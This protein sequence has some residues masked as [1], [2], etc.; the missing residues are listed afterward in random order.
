MA[1]IYFSDVFEVS[2][3]LLEEHGAFNISLITDLPL[4]IDPFLLF[5]SEDRKYKEL[6][7]SII[8]YMRF[9]KDES[10]DRSLPEPLVRQ[11]FTF[12]EIRQNW[13]GFSKVGNRGR[14]LGKD[15]A[16]VLNR[17]LNS[18]FSDFGQETVTLSSHIEKFC[19]IRDGVGRDMISDFTA[20]L[21]KGYLCEFTQEFARSH[22]PTSKRAVYNVDH[23]RFNC[24]TVSWAS[25]RFELPMLDT[26]YVL[27]TPKEILT[28][29][30]TWINRPDLI[31]SFRGI[32]DALPNA[33]LRAQVNEY[34]IRTLPNKPS[35][36]K[37]EIK[38][39]IRAA[40]SHAIEKFPQIL[41]YYI[42]KKEEDGDQ[43]VSAAKEHVNFV[44]EYLVQQ[45]SD[46]VQEIL[47]PGGF[48]QLRPDTYYDAKQRLLFLKDVIE[49][50]GGHR[51][52][53]VKGHPI[54]REEDLQILY[55]LTWFASDADVSREVNDGRGPA[56]YK[57]SRGSRDKTLVEF[58]L[59]KNTQ[60][61]R[62]LANQAK[63]YE[64][65]SD[66]T[67]PTL[68]AIL[69]FDEQQL[70]KVQDILKRLEMETSPNIILI[71]AGED[72]KPSGSRA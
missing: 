56:D 45:V 70:L 24:E 23:V 15:F 39:E 55:R 34:L 60:L 44:Q 33:S 22:L 5:N 25:E 67:Q 4:F 35:Q 68:K 6:H 26:D 38:K 32:A 14:G 17:N 40:I 63:I 62:N 69:Y 57:V 72:N 61:A 36:N 53:Y 20:N 29:D 28:R 59:A 64:R 11:W 16:K 66:A 18:V 47:V 49:N 30:E 43:A 13:L 1:N 27:L 51:L 46:F 12:P 31:D 3:E 52:F 9:L 21:V 50:K 10:K 41:D 65:A 58:K 54:E 19:L 71:D 7:D 48:Y 42:R 8:E 37:K 2:P